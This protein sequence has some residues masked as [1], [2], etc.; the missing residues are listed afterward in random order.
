MIDSHLHCWTPGD[1]FLV[2]VRERF[3]RL[4]RRFGLAEAAPLCRDAG[5]SG[6][7]LVSSAQDAG[8]TDRLFAEAGC[9]AFPVVGVVGFLDPAMDDV[10]A[11]LERWT[12]SPLFAGLRLPLPVMPNGWLEAPGTQ[13]LLDQ[14]ARRRLI[15]EILALPEQLPEVLVSLQR[16]PG[17]RTIIDHAANPPVATG[18][19]HPW[20]AWMGRV[21]R[22]TSAV[23]KICDFHQAGEA[24]LTDDAIL[25]FLRH[26]LEVFGP[27]RLMAGSNWPVSSLHGGYG[28]SFARLDRLSRRLGLDIQGRAAVFEDNGRALFSA[29]AKAP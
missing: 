25:P 26:L 7:V 10:A 22:E 17:L 11:R 5:I 19:L 16:R 18:A 6:V 24:D 9:G 23:C 13:A 20:A 14:L 3:E 21:A 12:A 2:K 1:G 27:E 8:E 4:D 15:A 28:N 29:E